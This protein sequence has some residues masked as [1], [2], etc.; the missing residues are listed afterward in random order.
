MW[1]ATFCELRI[2][3][4]E[5]YTDPTAFLMEGPNYGVMNRPRVGHKGSFGS[6]L[7]IGGWPP[8]QGAGG[9]AGLAALRAGQAK[10]TFAVLPSQNALS[11]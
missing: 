7:V 11:N 6:V 3:K 8:M 10:Y 1:K 5:N 4:P 2:E 9:M